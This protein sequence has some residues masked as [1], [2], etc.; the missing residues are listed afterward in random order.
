MSSPTT[1]LSIVQAA[2][3]LNRSDRWVQQ[4]VAEGFIAKAERGRYRL[5]SVIRGAIA[6]QEAQL[7]KRQNA[8]V[9]NRAT[10]ARTRETELRI[11]ER[12]RGL[13]ARADVEAV[14]AEMVDIVKA[15]FSGLPARATEDR[16]ARRK[17]GV[18]V[19]AAFAR[20]DA[21]AEQARLDLARGFEE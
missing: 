13:I 10:D 20:I 3:L 18:E 7:A 12:Q 16:S 15:E 1:T 21:A 8:N 4:R 11:A 2:A 17:L 19:D 9:P 14:V 6:Y 5:V